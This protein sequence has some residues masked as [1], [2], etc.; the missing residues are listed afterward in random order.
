MLA[1]RVKTLYVPFLTEKMA[2]LHTFHWQ[3]AVFL[4][5]IYLVYNLLKITA[6]CQTNMSLT[7]ISNVTKSKNELWRTVSGLQLESCFNL[8]QVCPSVSPFV[9][10]VLSI[11][12]SFHVFRCVEP[13]I[14]C[15]TQFGDGSHCS[16]FDDFSVTASLTIPLWPDI[17][18]FS[19]LFQCKIRKLPTYPS[20]KPTLSLTSH[21]GQN[22]GLGEG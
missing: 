4:S 13:F 11:Q 5:H 3:M 8:L 15:F 10:A 18:L 19:F 7:I 17:L 1:T 16:Y 22:V 6:S 21:F 9:F 12:S 2:L 14:L 20:P